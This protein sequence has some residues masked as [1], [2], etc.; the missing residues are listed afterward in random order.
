MEK[1]YKKGSQFLGNINN[2][3]F[4]GEINPK[5]QFTT[6]LTHRHVEIWRQGDTDIQTDGQTD[7][8]IE[9]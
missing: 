9:I 3:T 7:P 2:L 1:C 8:F 6:M 5:L 4:F